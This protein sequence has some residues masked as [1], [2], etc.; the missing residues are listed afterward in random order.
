MIDFSIAIK[1]IVNTKGNMTMFMNAKGSDNGHQFLE[2][3]VVGQIF[4]FK[5]TTIAKDRGK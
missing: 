4:N 3:R 2:V 5:S 1:Y